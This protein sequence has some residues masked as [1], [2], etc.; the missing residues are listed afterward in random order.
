MIVQ[1][2]RE[3]DQA[4]P[5]P[6]VFQGRDLAQSPHLRLR[7]AGQPVRGAAATAPRVSTHSG[8]LIPASPSPC[9]SATVPARPRV[10]TG[11]AAAGA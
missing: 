5:P 4:A 10:T 11:K 2:G 7:R 9:T 6:G 3:V 1:G 8:A